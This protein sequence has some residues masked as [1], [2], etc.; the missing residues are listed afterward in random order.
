MLLLH[1]YCTHVLFLGLLLLDGYIWAYDWQRLAIWQARPSGRMLGQDW[2]FK[3]LDGMCVLAH[4]WAGKKATLGD[5][6]ITTFNEWPMH[7]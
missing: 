6:Y 3:I 7:F 4:Y 1:F 2:H 5:D